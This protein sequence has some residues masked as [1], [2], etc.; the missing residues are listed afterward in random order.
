MRSK[1][2]PT[3]LQITD[4]L[5]GELLGEGDTRI[6]GLATLH[7]AT[8]GD[9]TFLT[10]NRYRHLLDGTRASAVLLGPTAANW[11]SKPRIV[12][13]A[14]YVYLARLVA[15]LFPEPPLKPGVHPS[16]MVDPDAR[17]STSA[18]I[19]AGAVISSGAHIGD[20]VRVGP[21]CVVGVDAS[22]GSDS[23][24]H[25]NVTVYHHCRIGRRCILHS[26]AVIGA[27][28]FG[29]AQSDGR[30]IK[31]PQIG[32]V[33][34]GDDV[35]VGANTTIDRGALDDT[36]IEDGVKLDNQIQIGH[37]VRIGAH[38]AIAG[39]VGIAGSARVGAHCTLGGGAIILGHIELADDVHIGAGSLVAKSIPNA[40]RYSGI[41]PLQT[42]ADWS[43][44]AV[45]L[46]RLPDLEERVRRIEVKVARETPE[47]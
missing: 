32:A 28:G 12:S 2:Q 36:V 14:P 27:D 47:E 30:W 29:M 38:T 33:V 46:R 26:G 23:T 11:T 7:S 3:L 24:L 22:I 40:G 25:P 37:N 42:N 10:S 15:F 6:S 19:G 9:I 13:E 1:I 17:V 18:S 44:G 5:G 35:E 34:I 31:I 4:R 20:H 39:C 41:Y 45:H 16:A 43:R 21:G 8:A